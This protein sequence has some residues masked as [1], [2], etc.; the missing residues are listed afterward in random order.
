MAL[1]SAD[2]HKSLTELNGG[3]KRDV[4][5]LIKP[6][7]SAPRRNTYHI[8]PVA[9]LVIASVVDGFVF[10]DGAGAEGGERGV[11]GGGRGDADGE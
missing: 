4:A 8:A 7:V 3:Q 5:H 9:G 10:P 2:K 11:V 6:A 1:P